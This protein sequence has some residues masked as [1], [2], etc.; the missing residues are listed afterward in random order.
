MAM[1]F[2]NVWSPNDFQNILI[3]KFNSQYCSTTQ[4]VCL[5]FNGCTLFSKNKLKKLAFPSRLL[6]VVELKVF[7]YHFKKFSK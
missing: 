7:S 4:R 1:G 5:I 3:F 2:A 6:Q